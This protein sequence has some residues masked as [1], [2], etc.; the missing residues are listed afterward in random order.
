[1]T[2]LANA[3]NY[4]EGT[5]FRLFPQL[6]NLAAF[7]EPE[8]VWL[9]PPAGSLAPGPADNRMY[10]VDPI[11]KPEPYGFPY[12]PPYRGPVYPPVMP[13]ENGH[14]DYL[15]VG[16]R[17]FLAAHMYGTLRF[18]LD[19]WE[20]YFGYTIPWHFQAH[21]PR[22]EL[23]PLIP[24]NNAHSGY[25]FIE[26]G[27]GTA[28]FGETPPLSLNFDVLAHEIGHSILFS[29]VGL[30]SD[31]TRT[32]GY[33]GFQESASD[34]M[35][36]IAVLHFNSV[37]DHLL[38]TSQG[39]LYTLNELNRIGEVSETEQIRVASNPHKMTD[40]AA[41]EDDVHRLAGPLTGAIFDILIDLFLDNLVEQG[42]I[43]PTLIELSYLSPEQAEALQRPF[44]EA[45]QGHHRNFKQAL[46]A[47]RDY[48]GLLLAT[49]WGRLSPDYLNYNH[50][51]Q[52]LL[53]ADRELSG[54]RYQQII[55]ENF[56]WREI[57]LIA[58]DNATLMAH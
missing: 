36:L 31:S 56:A 9:S 3:D 45:Y 23:V 35:A 51:G 43:S 6:P 55:L 5:R 18:V 20:G 4:Y 2:M 44:A 24:W 19:V 16:S 11:N 30:P 53:A 10:V 42:L 58:A 29:Q 54:G 25:G 50:I 26:F 37:V 41:D 40:F 13:D 22:L 48:M 33:S 52:A 28:R 7:S 49:G 34:L 46:V 47:A 38:E 32:N 12:L 39:N 14:F 57:H 27:D 21:Y 15:E 8:T 1:M 17:E